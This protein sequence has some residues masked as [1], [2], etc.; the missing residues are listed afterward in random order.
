MTPKKYL[1]LFIVLFLLNGI[2]Q[3]LAGKTVI[4]PMFL[5]DDTVE[6]KNIGTIKIENESCGV[7]F[8]PNLHDLPPGVHGFHIH[9][10]P[11]CADKG[12]AALSHYDPAKT[13]KHEGPYEKHGHK[14]DLPVLIV[15]K[16]GHASL[17]SL[18]PHLKLSMLKNHAIMIHA[19]ADNYADTPEK[20]G[21]GGARIA[22]GVI[23]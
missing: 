17:P 2:N 21:G 18:A 11:S 5:T 19:G 12:M 7:L 3:A 14:G 23:H 13:E 8:I 9:E 16:N 4:V 6:G 20:L 1:S 10:K 15:D 22:C